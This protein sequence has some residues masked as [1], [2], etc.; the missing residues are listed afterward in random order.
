MVQ[1]EKQMSERCVL[2]DPIYMGVPWAVTSVVG[3]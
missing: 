2:C 3:L 1:V